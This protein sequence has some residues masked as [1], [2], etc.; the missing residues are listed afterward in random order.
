MTTRKQERY[1]SKSIGERGHRVRLYE[2]RLAG[3]IMRSV[4][5]NGKE[6]R[7]SLK[8][9]DKERAV[10]QGYELLSALLSNEK[11]LDE[12]SVTLG[13]LSDLYLKS[14]AHLS[15]KPR[16]QQDED[17]MLCRVVGFIGKTRNVDSL[18]ESDVTRYTQARRLGQIKEPGA[19]KGRAVGD[20]TIGADLE[21]LLRALRWGMRERTTSG[22]RLLKE[23]PLVG[24][25]LPSEKNPRRPVMIHD[26]YLKLL[27]VA[28]RVHPLLKLALIVAEGTGRRLS[29]WRNLLWGDVDFEAK[30]IRWRAEHDKKGYEQVV[31]MSEAV[32]K[33]LTASRR[34]QQAIGN[35]PV[36][37]APRNPAASCS[38]H[39]MDAWLRTAHILAKV[40]LQ[41]RGMWHSLRRKWAT[42]RKG[43][44]L[45]D[46]AFAGGWRTERT[47]LSSY[48][49][50][51]AETVRQVVLYPTHRLRNTRAKK[52][53]QQ[54]SQHRSGEEKS[55]AA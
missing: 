21:M 11:A 36:F 42:E 29:A 43:Y 31:P 55:P 40:D 51:D 1:W 44:P 49:Q 26:D 15:K 48:Q 4:Y 35:T 47:I 23:N 9:R 25:R 13:L 8:H 41:P 24:L 50:A 32:K 53:S 5:T 10:R 39:V 33:A 12:G 52:N 7:K 37:P 45:K 34:Q 27:K 18:S 17:K 38:R 6:A 54:D 46:V 28:A 3:P 20:R 14:P 30:A 22:R 16:T 19:E 2:A